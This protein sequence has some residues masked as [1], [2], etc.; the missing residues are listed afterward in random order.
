[1][2]CGDCGSTKTRET[3]LLEGPP[4]LQTPAL[5]TGVRLRSK[6]SVKADA[7]PRIAKPRVVIRPIV[8]TSAG[9]TP[10]QRTARKGAGRRNAESLNA[11]NEELRLQQ[12]L[13]GQLLAV[14]TELGPGHGVQ[15][16]LGD[17]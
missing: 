14:D 3:L 1:M 15:T 13:L 8:R 7:S 9:P 5:E 6:V 16:L 12:P 4:V 17:G 10:C 11:G 2:V